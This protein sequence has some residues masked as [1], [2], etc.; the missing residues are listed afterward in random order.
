MA[1]KL[2]VICRY[3]YPLLTSILVLATWWLETHIP[4]D[5]S[6]VDAT[7]SGEP[8]PGSVGGRVVLESGVEAGE[9]EI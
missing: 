5:I 1:A 6:G 7:G 3:H 9:K 4:D 2:A 8:S